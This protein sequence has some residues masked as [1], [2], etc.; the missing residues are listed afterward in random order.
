ML[1]SIYF[2]AFFQRCKRNKEDELNKTFMMFYFFSTITIIITLVNQNII[3]NYL[4]DDPIYSYIRP[5]FVGLSTS[6]GA[7]ASNTFL[8][9]AKKLFD[10]NNN[11]KVTI[12]LDIF[13]LLTTSINIIVV[14]ITGQMQSINLIL[15]FLMA[16]VFLIF[17]YFYIGYR[18][19]YNAYKFPVLNYTEEDALVFQ[20][21]FL[22]IGMTGLSQFLFGML[23][24]IDTFWD[25][26]TLYNFF[27]WIFCIISLIFAYY[28]F[29]K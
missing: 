20:N 26:Y 11:K 19:V 8:V 4:R 18:G 13:I 3:F 14:L 7:L 24:M 22:F 5:I 2:I 12:T 1:T 23:I 29:G 17:S 10:G 21:R 9:F 16:L 25:H 6:M 15:N 28:A 27:G